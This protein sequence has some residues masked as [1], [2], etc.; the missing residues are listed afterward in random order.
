M[1]ML[2][3]LCV[4]LTVPAIFSA[5]K[6]DESLVKKVKNGDKDEKLK[7]VTKIR[8]MLEEGLKNKDVIPVI[9]QFISA[10]VLVPLVDCLSEYNASHRQLVANAMSALAII[11]TQK[12]E[13]IF[14]VQ[15]VMDY[16][17]DWKK[18]SSDEEVKKNATSILMNIMPNLIANAKSADQ[19]KKL[20]AVTKI[21]EMLKG[22]T[23][24]Q[25]VDEF[26][27]KGVLN[28]L[29]GFLPED[30]ASWPQLVT[31]AMAALAIIA[32]EKAKEIIRANYKVG[33]YVENWIKNS[34]DDE[35]LKNA[36]S[37]LKNFLANENKQI[38]E[39]AMCAAYQLIK[40][41]GRIYD[42]TKA[43]QIQ[44]MAS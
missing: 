39:E 1:R 4:A 9:D 17:N 36:A 25:L 40:R 27:K 13:Q 7:A 26:I 5:Q 8:E 35:L 31:N 18:Y 41:N 10:G 32:T 24:K 22:N 34:T 12:A 33:D 16:L 20:D 38:F 42:E 15:N 43:A 23:D 11:A 28:P 14:K 37:L 19:E 44:T 6:K 3:L 2:T 30:N 21:H 29:I